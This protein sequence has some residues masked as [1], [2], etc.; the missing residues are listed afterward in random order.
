MNTI[1]Y[2]YIF[3]LF[4]PII[5]SIGIFPS[6]RTEKELMCINTEKPSF[7]DCTSI[8]AED[9]QFSCCF[10]KDGQFEKCVFIE[11]TEFGIETVKHIYS[12]YEDLSVECKSQRIDILFI[13]YIFLFILYI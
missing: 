10:I 1:F 4:I 2:L 5:F 13:L 3:L 9:E 11:N 6:E 8:K 7:K 12:D